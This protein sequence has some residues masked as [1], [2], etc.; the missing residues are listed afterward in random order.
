MHI[1]RI[2]G[3]ALKGGRSTRLATQLKSAAS[4]GFGGEPVKFI[5]QSMNKAKTCR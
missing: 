5:E 4:G 3:R 1:M 2:A